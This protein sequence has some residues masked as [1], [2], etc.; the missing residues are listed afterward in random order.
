MNLLRKIILFA[1]CFCLLSCAGADEKTVANN[2]SNQTQT[3]KERIKTL[4]ESVF[5]ISIAAKGKTFLPKDAVGTG[6]L[7]G[8]GLL[9]SALHVQTKAAEM[10]KYLDKNS[11]ELI[12]WK[13]FDAIDYAQFPIE[14]YS[15]DKNTDLAIFR[16]D[17][18][19]LKDKP[20]FAQIKPLALAENLPAL[21]EE[22]VSIG[23]FGE[24]QFPF[25]S[26][27]NVSMI[28]KNED[29]VSDLTIV[30]GNSGAPV[31]SLETGEVLGITVSVLNLGNETVRFGISKR[32]S[33]MRELL[34]NL[35]KKN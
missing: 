13:T 5:C 16:F 1:I 6:F 19:V 35:E 7:V 4:D 24:Y 17:A 32:A 31:C 29:I 14:L 21:G 25:N 28:D 27:G 9:A 30:P 12:A 34:Q 3:K 23:F 22:V 20:K 33:K 18:N 11:Y 15:F 2:V 8:D 10:L 26:M